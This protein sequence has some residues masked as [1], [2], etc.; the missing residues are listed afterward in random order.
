MTK[1]ERLAYVKAVYPA[2]WLRVRSVCR[3]AAFG[4]DVDDHAA[5]IILAAKEMRNR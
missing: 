1:Q 5:R 2:A 3:W 4:L